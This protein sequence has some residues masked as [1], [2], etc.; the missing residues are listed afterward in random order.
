M[1]SSVGSF[2]E[3]KHVLTLVWMCVGCVFIERQLQMAFRLDSTRCR[4]TCSSFVSGSI[5]AMVA[6]AMGEW[7]M[8]EK[9]IWFHC[10]CNHPPFQ[11][12]V[13]AFSKKPKR[14]YFF[15]KLSRKMLGW[16]ISFPE[17]RGS[18]FC[19]RER[20]CW[21]Q[22]SSDFVRILWPAFDEVEHT[23]SSLCLKRG[24]GGGFPIFS[25][26][27]QNRRDSTVW[28]K[29]K[30]FSLTLKVSQCWPQR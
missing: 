3:Y 12:Y 18:F 1:L 7:K 16:C 27:S 14:I 25:F 6:N 20:R 8:G 17:K 24:G 22:K 9:V 15:S 30:C 28:P 4:W 13:V 5:L 21:G 26:S 11:L 23:S 2:Y 29:Q 19:Y 10:S